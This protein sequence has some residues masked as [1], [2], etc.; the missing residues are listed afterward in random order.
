MVEPMSAIDELE[1][2]VLRRLAVEV[3]RVLFERDAGRFAM[4]VAHITAWETIS[5]ARG[6]AYVV[7]SLAH[8]FFCPKCRAFTGD[9]KELQ[10]TCRSCGASRPQ[11]LQS[12]A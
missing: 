11:V 10:V 4:L 8:G 2:G 12:Q 3:R 5:R 9:A 1:I 7:E 6:S